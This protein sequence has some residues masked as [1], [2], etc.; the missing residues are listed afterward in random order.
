[1]NLILETGLVI[2]TS[3]VSKY[4]SHSLISSHSKVIHNRSEIE[5]NSDVTISTWPSNQ[6]W[7]RAVIVFYRS[8][9][10]ESVYINLTRENVVLKWR[11]NY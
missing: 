10:Q 5:Y 3:R 9:R 6:Y 1:M 4:S 2:V 8:Q 11:R 7:V